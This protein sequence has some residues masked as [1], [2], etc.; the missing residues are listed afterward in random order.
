MKKGEVILALL[1]CIILPFIAFRF[2][3]DTGVPLPGPNRLRTTIAEPVNLMIEFDH[4]IETIELEEYLLGVVLAEMPASFSIDALK[5]QAVVA[6]T[7]ALKCLYN[8]KHTNADLCSKSSCCQGY[9][10]PDAYRSD[11]GSEESLMKI[12]EAVRSTKGLVLYY[13]DS[14]IDATYFSCSGGRTEAAVAVWG[15]DVPYL[16]AL[17]SPGEEQSLHY[18]DTITFSVADIIQKLQLRAD[19]NCVQV[20]R[21]SYTAGG[22]VDQITINGQSFTGVQVR[23]RLGLKSTAFVISVVAD[24]VTFTTKGYGHRV[25]MSQYGADAMAKEGHEFSQILS[26]YYPGTQLRRYDLPTD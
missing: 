24:T 12:K 6:R 10:A 16:Q 19:Q 4:A 26:Y 1:L 11:G 23:Q 3:H 22:G 21:V 7:F 17:E 20:E 14:L 9:Y 2:N 5:A 15:T 25:G 13:D 18:V 8:S